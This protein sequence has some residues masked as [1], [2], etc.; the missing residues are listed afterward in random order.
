MSDTSYDKAKSEML[1]YMQGTSANVAVELEF[2][3]M[4]LK[5]DLWSR[6]EICKSVSKTLQRVQESNA[7]VEKT[8]KESY[9]E[10][11]NALK[12]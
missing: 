6:E 11:I 2:A 5:G 1:G 12:I 8:L 10:T 9:D 7:H 3:V 4:N